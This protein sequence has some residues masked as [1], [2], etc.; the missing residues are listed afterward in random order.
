LDCEVVLPPPNVASAPAF[1]QTIEL[2][3][4]P[5]AGDDA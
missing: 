2:A 4:E 1:D 5:M 3:S